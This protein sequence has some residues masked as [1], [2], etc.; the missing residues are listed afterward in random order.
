MGTPRSFLVLGA[1]CGAR[2]V[3]QYTNTQYQYH[4]VCV[5]VCEPSQHEATVKQ[6]IS[7]ANPRGVMHAVD[8]DA[9]LPSSPEVQDAFVKWR[10]IHVP[11]EFRVSAPPAANVNKRW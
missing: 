3:I 11:C 1:V 9:F 8:L 10:A 7:D 5:C 2:I 6:K 4:C